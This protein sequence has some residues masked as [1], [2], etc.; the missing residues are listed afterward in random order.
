M[1]NLNLEN[2]KVNFPDEL[3][4]LLQATND[5]WTKFTEVLEEAK[6]SLEKSKVRLNH[7]SCCKIKMHEHFIF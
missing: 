5:G 7:N 2:Y 3:T 6:N 1:I 4:V